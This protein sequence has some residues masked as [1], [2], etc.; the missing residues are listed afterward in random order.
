MM[1]VVLTMLFVAGARFRDFLLFFL[2]GVVAFGLLAVGLALAWVGA[3]ALGLGVRDRHTDIAFARHAHRIMEEQGI[4]H[5]FREHPGGHAFGEKG[6]P[7]LRLRFS[8]NRLP[9]IGDDVVLQ[10]PRSILRDRNRLI[11][12]CPKTAHAGDLGL[13]KNKRL[14]SRER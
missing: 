3:H 10:Q 6:A 12:M 14:S 1:A 13:V 7:F 8:D 2:A 11:P 5:V 4:P 9:A